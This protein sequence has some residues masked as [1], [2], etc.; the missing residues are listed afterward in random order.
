MRLKIS[1]IC[2]QVLAMSMLLSLAACTG[3]K[4]ETLVV[5]LAAPPLSRTYIGYGVINVSYTHLAAE[6]GRE[7]VSSGYLRQGAVVGI[8]ERRVVRQ[9]DKSEV[10]VRVLGEASGWL[11]EE[12]I[13]IYDNEMQA[14]TA[15]KAMSL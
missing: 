6:P 4:A 12:S 14:Q 13:D 3:R 15:A 9:S 1:G 7:G 11:K 10:W 5:P 2:R 8:V